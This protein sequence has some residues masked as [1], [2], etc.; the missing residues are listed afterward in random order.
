MG[1]NFQ[2]PRSIKYKTPS[3]F[4]IY[5]NSSVS[6]VYINSSVSPLYIYKS[7]NILC[8]CNSYCIP[9]L[10]MYLYPSVSTV[11]VI[12]L[13]PCLCI[14]ISFSIT[15][16]IN[17]SVSPVHVILLVPLFM[18][19]SYILQYLLFIYILQYPLFM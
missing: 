2:V 18:Y 12:L 17:P 16:Y 3:V 6:P 1:S 15:V 19:I 13:F 7:F 8:S 5:V 10:I 14:H 9:Y 11:H 4:L